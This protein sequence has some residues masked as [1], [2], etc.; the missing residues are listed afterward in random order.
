MHGLKLA[1]TELNE[2]HKLTELNDKLDEI[3]ATADIALSSSRI[4]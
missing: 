1:Y 3:W 4:K 2:T